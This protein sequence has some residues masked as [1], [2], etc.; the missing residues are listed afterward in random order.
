MGDFG[1]DQKNKDE[2]IYLTGDEKEGWLHPTGT[3]HATLGKFLTGEA[4]PSWIRGLAKDA[5]GFGRAVPT[6]M[7]KLKEAY[8]TEEAMTAAAEAGVPL[9]N[10]RRYQISPNIDV[11]DPHRTMAQ[12]LPNLAVAIRS[13]EYSI[14]LPGTP[15]GKPL[16]DFI[17]KFHEDRIK[18]AIEAEKQSAGSRVNKQKD[19]PLS[20]A[21]TE[22]LGPTGNALQD[23]LNKKSPAHRAWELENVERLQ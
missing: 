15:E 6:T 22:G 1:R 2:I 7:E 5:M 8:L 3:M 20:M 4:V 18:A 19:W 14:P 17:N 16:W 10:I 21:L 9:G 12:D 13:G 11:R 23:L